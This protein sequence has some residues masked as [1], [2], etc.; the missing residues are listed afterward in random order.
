MP[1]P[2]RRPIDAYTPPP[3]SVAE[4]TPTA[5]RVALLLQIQARASQISPVLYV[6]EALKKATA[7]P[8][9]LA[10]VAA[11]HFVNARYFADRD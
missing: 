8:P 5:P 3:I 10:Y 1:P 2:T 6:A 7:V 9:P 11:H 4:H